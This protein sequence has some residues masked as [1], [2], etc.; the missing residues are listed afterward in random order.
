MK[1]LKKLKMHLNI[2]KSLHEKRENSEIF[3]LLNGFC[4][5]NFNQSNINNQEIGI[6]CFLSLIKFINLN[7]NNN[8]IDLQ[9]IIW[10]NRSDL[11]ENNNA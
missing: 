6:Q 11:L 5:Y 7:D 3:K 4:I 10:E 9:K 8:D 2:I 1:T